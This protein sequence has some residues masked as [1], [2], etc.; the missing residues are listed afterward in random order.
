MAISKATLTAIHKT[1]VVT[2][3]LQTA[4]RTEAKKYADRLSKALADSADGQVFE[5]LDGPLVN[6]WKGVGRL[7]KMVESIEKE[8]MAVMQLATELVAD[9]QKVSEEIL[10][11][12]VPKPVA[13]APKKMP[14]SGKANVAASKKESNPT[15]LLSVLTA[16]LSSDAFTI[17]TQTELAK[18][19][20]IPMGSIAATIKRVAASGAVEINADGTG[21][22]LA[23]KAIQAPAAKPK[24]LSKA[25]A[26]PQTPTPVVA[27]VA[28]APVTPTPVTPTPAKKAA[29]KK[30]TTKK[31]AAKTVA[32]DKPKAKKA[33]AKKAAA[34]DAAPA[35]AVNAEP[36]AT[37]DAPAAV[38]TAS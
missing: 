17:L 28:P 36:P 12:S 30:A 16:K 19:A 31:P 20:G 6:H 27:S 2:Q 34:N 21:Y 22:K 1:G 8:L 32:A 5:L 9:V 10:A 14:A 24:K 33:V 4:L 37:T 23:S 25:T 26:S 18:A 35:V 38:E 15:K 11:A 7:S 3:N 13:A 29:A